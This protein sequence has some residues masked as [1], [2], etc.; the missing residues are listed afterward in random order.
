MSSGK[1]CDSGVAKWMDAHAASLPAWWSRRSVPVL[2][3]TEKIQVDVRL[4]ASDAAL[5]RALSRS[6]NTSLSALLSRMVESTARAFRTGRNPTTGELLS[7]AE[8][9]RPADV[10][11]ATRGESPSKVDV[12]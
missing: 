6:S 1:H 7:W 12:G 3:K 2:G 10:K 5:L 8:D 4:S 11:A 9:T